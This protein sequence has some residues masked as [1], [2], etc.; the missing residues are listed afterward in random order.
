MWSSTSAHETPAGTRPIAGA[1][2]S[3]Y[4][5]SSSTGLLPRHRGG[6]ATISH[7]GPPETPPPGDYSPAS[8]VELADQRLRGA[9]G[10]AHYDEFGHGISASESGDISPRRA[11]ALASQKTPNTERYQYDRAY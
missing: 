10:D 2:L 6:A 11:G 4:V 9:F 1:S 7:S 8:A 3:S 5:R